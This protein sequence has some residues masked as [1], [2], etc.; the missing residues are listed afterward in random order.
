MSAAHSTVRSAFDLTAT[1]YDRA[2]RQ[3]VPCFDEFY[4]AAVAMLDFPREAPLEALDLGAGTGLMAGF[5]A[6]AF[7]G[8][9]I[10][11]IDI[12]PAMLAR[13]QARLAPVIDRIRIIEADYV[14]A[15][16]GG[17][18][19]AIVSA[20]SI[21]HLEDPDKRGL[22]GRI[23]GALKPGGI[24]VNADQVAGATPARER[25]HKD[26]WIAHARGRGVAED[27]LAAAIDRMK[28][29]RPATVAAQLRWLQEAGFASVDCAFKA[30]MFAVFGGY[31]LS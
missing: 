15:P 28:C 31:R 22:F 21:H 11:L 29:D 25:R 20:L 2:R 26:E 3:L 9:R 19:D 8:A 10:T 13:A 4:R 14:Q 24:F 27:D 16:L 1:E 23:F 18:F 17:P 6:S 5:V 12:A 7:P 30:G